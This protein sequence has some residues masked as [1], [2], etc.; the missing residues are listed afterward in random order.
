MSDHLIGLLLGTEEDWPQAF[1]TLLRRV[2]PIRI[3][4]GRT[5]R[6]P[7]GSPSSRSTCATRSA[8]TLVI[9]RLAYWYY[10][11][12]E[13]LKKAA[14]VNDTYLL[15]NPFTF[16]SMEK[17]SR[18]L[19]DDP[20]RPRRCPKTVLVPYKNPV[21][22]ERWAYTAAKYNQPFDLDEVADRGRLPAVHEAVRRRRLA[23]RLADRR[24]RRPAPRL[25]RVRRD[26]HAPAGDRRVR[27]V[28]PVALHRPGDDGDGVPA[29]AADARPVRR[30]ARLPAAR[31]RA[32][33]SAICRIVNAF[34]RWEFNS[35]EMLVTGDE[36]YPID[37]ANACPDVAVTSLHYYFP[38]AITALVRGRCSASS[39]A[40]RPRVDLRPAGTS[41]SPTIR[42]W[43]TRTSSGLPRARRRVLRDRHAT[44]SAAR[45]PGVTSTE[46]S[47]TG[48]P[49]RTSTGCCWRPCERRTRRT[50]RSG[51]SPTSAA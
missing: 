30:V 8:T 5:R 3:E 2:D 32:R 16:Q 50:S 26:A 1:E 34:F 44:T 17:H 22:N 10:H 35:C 28:R 23:R 19:R 42:T 41:T 24:Q 21:D 45:P 15:N 9:D 13:W 4:G 43:T 27:H 46:R 11:P 20:A 47:T 51:S 33:R 39:P 7:S 18:V 37:Y 48:S 49:R 6:A 14:L 36:V 40:A 25:R 29:G 31:G 38:W 12:R